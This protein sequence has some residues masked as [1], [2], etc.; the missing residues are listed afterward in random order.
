MG[1]HR[2]KRLQKW[3][4]LQAVIWLAG[5]QLAN[6]QGEHEV[7]VFYAP[8][9]PLK[10]KKKS[11][12]LEYT[13]IRDHKSIVT[14]QFLNGQRSWLRSVLENFQNSNIQKSIQWWL[15]Y[16]VTCSERKGEYY[17]GCYGK[18]SQRKCKTLSV[19]LH[20][21]FSL[22]PNTLR[23]YKKITQK[24]KHNKHKG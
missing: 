1:W 8:N 23:L 12:Q 24:A 13:P 4:S 10:K 11:Q 15:T 17:L 18:Y 7:P 9:S 2:I 6:Y 14:T 21:E 22:W 16:L 5:N 19:S 20:T 3:M